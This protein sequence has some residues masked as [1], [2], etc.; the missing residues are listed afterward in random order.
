M[1]SID[2]VIPCYRYGHFLSDCVQSVLAQSGVTVRVLII[3]DASPDNTA[4]VAREWARADSR[5][6]VLKHASNR[7]HI[8]TFNEGIAWAAADY[9]V[10]L[11]ADDY[12]L[13]GALARSTRVMDDHPSVGLV[14]GRA[15]VQQD[16]RT[17]DVAAPPGLGPGTRILSGIEFIH[18][19]RAKN[20]VL[21]PTVVVRTSLQKKVGGYSPQLTHSG[22]MGMW[23]RFAA[24][25]ELGF[26]DQAQ[27]VYRR[28]TTNM[29]TTYS[30]EQ[31]LAQR[32]EAFEDFLS[33]CAPVLANIDDLRTWFVH[34]L[35][36]D[37]VRSASRAFNEGAMGLSDRLCN[38]A[39]EMDPS[40]GS[41]LSWF[42]LGC[43]RRLGLRASQFLRP[44]VDLAR[45][46]LWR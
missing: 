22:D 27:A 6:N 31:D 2:V 36:L 33:S 17:E 19:S 12:L 28:H 1:R 24:H 21:A 16:D 7:G 30:P 39:L 9:M 40:V 37:A 32:R 4:D 8:A 18:L 20:I 25:A 42:V 35:A 11:S 43:K 5:V 15:I 26:I 29:S 23:L 3:D 13:P 14:F 34:E 45:Q 46:M 38:A 44:A 10:L 41:S